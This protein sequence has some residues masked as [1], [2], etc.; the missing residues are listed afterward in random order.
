[1]LKHYDSVLQAL[2]LDTFYKTDQ[3]LKQL[4]HTL[5]TVRTYGKHYDSVLQALCLDTFY[6]TDQQLKQLTHTNV[7]GECDLAGHVIH[8]HAGRVE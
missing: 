5:L 8:K 1:M 7:I 3:Q 6:K 2:C 4:T